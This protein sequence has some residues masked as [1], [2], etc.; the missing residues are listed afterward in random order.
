VVLL[1]GLGTSVCGGSN[2]S[3]N[4]AG[5]AGGPAGPSGGSGATCS[6]FSVLG[7]AAGTIS[8]RIDGAVFN[9][10]VPAAYAT[11]TA[12]AAV[13][14]LGIPA[15]DFVSIQG[16]C[17]DN[18]SLLLLAKARV[19]S[20]SF[21]LNTIDPETRNL[22]V[23]TAT[24]QYRTATGAGGAWLTSLLGGTGTIT[25]TSVSRA[26]AAGSFS[27]T[28]VPQAGTSASGNKQVTGDFN[29]TF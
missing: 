12:V 24:L 2:S 23:N 20:T 18:T 16:L 6:S 13:P 7:A 17:G 15:Q 25:F 21:G 4:A 28:M 1:F 14:T 29:V 8:A 10:G 5:N 3:N 11:Y 19:G 27:L 26:G 9:G 22:H